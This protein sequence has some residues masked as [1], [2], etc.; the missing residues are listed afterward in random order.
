MIE[1]IKIRST[2]GGLMAEINFFQASFGWTMSEAV[3]DGGA[4]QRVKN[5][6]IM[7]DG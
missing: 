7:I 2:V 6:I 4:M 3:T 5:I 1:F